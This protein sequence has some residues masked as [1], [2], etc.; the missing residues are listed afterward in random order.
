MDERGRHRAGPEPWPVA[1]TRPFSHRRIAPSGDAGF[2]WR[3]R[4]RNLQ[5]PD[6]ESEASGTGEAFRRTTTP[7]RGRRRPPWPTGPPLP[8]A[9]SQPGRSS[10]ARQAH[11]D[12]AHRPMAG[13]PSRASSPGRAASAG[14]RLRRRLVVQTGRV[15]PTLSAPADSGARVP[16]ASGAPPVARWK[17]IL[18]A[19][20]PIW[21]GAGTALRVWE[22]TPLGR[23]LWA[24]AVAEADPADGAG[25]RGTPDPAEPSARSAAPGCGG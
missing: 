19:F 16:R 17:A 15:R 25:R 12:L 9:W 6:A 2:G 1:V 13:A 18:A 4:I 5:S 11:S 8:R 3:G 24:V 10:P 20:P 22:V 7:G 21:P 23:L 14:T